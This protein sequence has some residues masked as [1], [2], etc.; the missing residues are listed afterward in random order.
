ME[1]AGRITALQAF[2]ALRNG[3]PNSH[4]VRALGCMQPAAWDAFQA[5]L[6]RL[7][8]PEETPPLVD[9]MLIAGGFGTG[10]SHTLSYFEQKALERNFI[11]SRVV[12]S[13]ETPLYDPAKLFVAAVREAR[14]PKSRGALI[15][16]LAS[17]IDYCSPSAAPFTTWACR[18]QPYGI[19]GA[20]VAIHERSNDAE[21]LQRVV[22][23]WAGEKLAVQA[24]RAG[25][26]SLD[27]T[28]AYDV[29][30]VK[31]ADLAPV[32]FEFTARLARAVGFKGWVILLDE[33]ELI[34]RY[35][36]LQRAKSYGSLARWLGA[37]PGHGVRGAFFVAAITDDFALDVLEQ[38][39]DREKIQ[40][41]IGERDAK[42]F[43]IAQ[44]ATAGMDQIQKRAIVLNPPND[45]TLE[46]SYHHLRKLYGV[47]YGKEPSLEFEAERGAHRP[48]R[49]YVR[50]W[51]LGWDLERLDPAMKLDTEEEAV[52]VRYD[53]D[54][55]LESREEPE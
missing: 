40:T 37:L 52:S 28:K 27:L 51:V 48:M 29:K 32:R 34:A 35:S 49:S 31:L 23:F 38:R 25:L 36:L 26:K 24:V 50:R 55:A 19:I 43:A 15:D 4:A 54:D 17:R 47:A 39:R 3:V 10:K 21:L 44:E 18:E 41:R 6:G 20:T 46:R 7:E 16:E 30:A 11:V 1:G 33:V 22:D 8:Q 13:K 14:L 53:E 9:G 12:I 5:R 45:D 42:G 2:E